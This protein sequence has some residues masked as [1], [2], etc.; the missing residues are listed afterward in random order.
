MNSVMNI[1][2]NVFTYSAL[3]SVVNEASPKRLHATASVLLLL[4]KLKAN[5]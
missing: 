4:V 2:R 5:D 1:L 3:T